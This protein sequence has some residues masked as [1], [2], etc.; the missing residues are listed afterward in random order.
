MYTFPAMNHQ[1][2]L[3]S[4]MRAS[5]HCLQFKLSES[6]LSATHLHC[7]LAV[8]AA[9]SDSLLPWSPDNFTAL[10]ERVFFD[11]VPS[12]DAWRST[13]PTCKIQSISFVAHKHSQRDSFHRCQIA[14]HGEKT[15]RMFPFEAGINQWKLMIYVWISAT[16]NVA[17]NWVNRLS[18]Q[19]KIH[20]CRF[21]KFFCSFVASDEYAYSI[22]HPYA[23]LGY[24]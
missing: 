12:A 20:K 4:A 24:L 18:L 22:P 3:R 9:A 5:F 13:N 17:F 23:T 7:P 14:G 21:H 1:Q 15:Q 2:H 8:S 19:A 6:E 11:D 16:A 10:L